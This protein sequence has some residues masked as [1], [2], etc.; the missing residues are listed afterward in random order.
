MA[1]ACKGWQ[2]WLLK[3]ESMIENAEVCPILGD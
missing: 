1:T 3:M 2:T